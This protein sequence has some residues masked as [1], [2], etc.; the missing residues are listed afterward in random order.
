MVTA[1]QQFTSLWQQSRLLKTW[2][3]LR[4]SLRTAQ[5]RDALDFLEFEVDINER[6]KQIRQEIIAGTY[7]PTTGRTFQVAKSK[8]AYRVI[9]VLGPRDLLVFRHLCDEIYRRALKYE[10]D[11]AYFGQRHPSVR[12]VGDEVTEPAADFYESA[13]PVWLRYHQYRTQTLLNPIRPVLV[14]TDVTNF[15]ESIQ[16]DLLLE[17]LSPLGLPRK[18]IGLLAKLLEIY[19]PSSGHSPTPKV[20]LPVDEHDCSRQLA[21]VF[22]F[23]HDERVIKQVGNGHYVRWMDDQNICASSETDARKLVRLLTESLSQ[24]RLVLNAAKT[25]FLTPAGVAADFHLEVNDEIDHIEEGLDQRTMG[26]LNARLLFNAAYTNALEAEGVG[27]WDK[28]LKR[29]Y[30]LGARIRNRRLRGRAYDDLVRYPLLAERIFQYFV[31]LGEWEGLYSLFTSFVDTGESLYEDVET[32]FFET[33]LLANIPDDRRAE[34][35]ELAR[36]WTVGEVEGS[37]R[38]Q[39]RGPAA[40]CLFW[41]GDRRSLITI[42]RVLENSGRSL[43]PQVSRS[44]LSA[45]LGLAPDRVATATEYCAEIGVPTAASLATLVKRLRDDDG[46]RLQLPNVE[47][48]KPKSLGFEVFEARTWIRLEILS[49]AASPNIQEWLQRQQNRLAARTLGTCEIRA[50]NRWGNHP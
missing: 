1:D 12:P 7:S 17:Y 32:T 44:L 27:N 14:T 46:L 41:L 6:I 19:K 24:Q 4:K 20:G 40:L 31:A 50:F 5:V 47:P 48:R 10:A 23:E 33:L 15:F 45:Y 29:M 2:K 38:A 16:H 3:V 8:G 36:R 28:I 34:F 43:P 11:G 22:L 9:S 49:L 35:R 13:F 30:G 21:H 26:M 25:E 39:S 42:E 18:A 37:G